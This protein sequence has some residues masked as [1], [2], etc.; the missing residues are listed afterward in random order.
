MGAVRG[1]GVVSTR[2][3]GAIAGSVPSAGTGGSERGGTVSDA[4]CPGSEVVGSSGTEVIDPKDLV[5]DVTATDGVGEPELGAAADMG[6]DVGVEAVGA[7]APT[8]GAAAQAANAPAASS[9]TATCT[10]RQRSPSFRGR[11]ITDRR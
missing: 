3:K 11:L 9:A 1:G 6:A 2:V 7:A 5:A 10:A 8:S 4:L